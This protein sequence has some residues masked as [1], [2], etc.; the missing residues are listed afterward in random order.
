[1]KWINYFFKDKFSNSSKSIDCALFTVHHPSSIIHYPLIVICALLSVNL[2]CAC[3][4]Y[5]TP[6]RDTWGHYLAG[7]SFAD[8]TAEGKIAKRPVYLG[9]GG[10][11]VGTDANAAKLDYGDK[12]ANDNAAT[13]NYMANLEYELYDSLR[14]PGIS[15]QRAGTDV[16]VILVRDSL[17]RLDAAELSD[18]GIDTLGIIA[19]ILQKH[20]ASYIEIAGYTDSFANQTGARALSLDMAQRV[21]LFLAR[22][23][24]NTARMFVVGRGSARP[25]AAQDDMGRLTNRRV[26]MRISPAR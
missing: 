1:V 24:I 5:T 16:V 13:V 9:A 12:I 7:A 11:I 18:T 8:M 22:H 26:E 23:K 20:D 14:K 4:Q 10:K 17:M 6:P 19:K 2:L 25:I 15:V 3:A 21:A